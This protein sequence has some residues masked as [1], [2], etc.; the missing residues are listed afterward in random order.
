MKY[1]LGLI[2]IIAAAYFFPQIYEEAGNSCQA[3]EK[4]ALRL[5]T[6]GTTVGSA[7]GGLALSLTNG[8]LG[9]DMAEDEYPSLPE[10]L[11][12]AVTYYNFPENWRP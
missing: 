12:C 8:E 6:D 1:L 5:N 10:P 9:R 2:V 7:L 3:L 4:K 11:G